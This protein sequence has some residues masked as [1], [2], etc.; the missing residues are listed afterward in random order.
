MHANVDSS[1]RVTIYYE[2]QHEHLVAEHD[3]DGNPSKI[4]LPCSG[5]C[6]DLLTVDANVVSSFCSNCFKDDLH[7][8]SDNFGTPGYEHAAG[9][10]E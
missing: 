1:G 7:V 10:P 5:H 6:G 2:C 3:E 4:Y 9:Y 8:S